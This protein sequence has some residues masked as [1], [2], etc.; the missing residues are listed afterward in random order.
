MELVSEIIDFRRCLILAIPTCKDPDLIGRF[1]TRTRSKSPCEC[2]RLWKK[3]N[4]KMPKWPKNDQKFYPEL[5]YFN[6]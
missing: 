3:N 1:R 2:C 6:I 4:Q 5:I